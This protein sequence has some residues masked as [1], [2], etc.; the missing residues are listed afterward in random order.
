[1]RSPRKR[2]REALGGKGRWK[3]S[4]PVTLTTLVGVTNNQTTAEKASGL[5]PQPRA[6]AQL[7]L[8]SDGRLTGRQVYSRTRLCVHLANRL[9]VRAI[10]EAEHSTR[11]RMT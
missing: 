1:M 8:L 5:V 3:T 9:A 7:V 11:K 10:E 6:S 2:D 4:F